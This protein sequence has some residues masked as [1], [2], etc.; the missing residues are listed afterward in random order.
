MAP[1]S[2]A[3]HDD[4][5]ND[6]H[7]RDQAGEVDGQPQLAEP[8]GEPP[9]PRASLGRKR[10]SALRSCLSACGT[11]GRG[12]RAFGYRIVFSTAGVQLPPERVP[13]RRPSSKA[14]CDSIG[15]RDRVYGMRREP[16]NRCGGQPCQRRSRKKAAAV[17]ASAELNQ[18]PGRFGMTPLISGSEEK[19]PGFTC[20]GRD[21][22][23]AVDSNATRTHAIPSTHSKCRSA[24]IRSAP[25]SN[26]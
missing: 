3:S 7:R 17:S 25:V 20:P 11:W 12:W 8:R 24:E 5:E 18:F 21:Q 16:G 2:I 4:V 19:A 6:A 13:V 14:A 22:P 26:A 10:D 1:G 23:P 15:G 9:H